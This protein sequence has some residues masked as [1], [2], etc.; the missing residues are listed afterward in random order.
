MFTHRIISSNYQQSEIFGFD[1][2]ERKRIISPSTSYYI[3]NILSDN[4][5]RVSAFGYSNNLG[6]KEKQVAVKTGTTQNIK[7]NWAIG[8][9]NNFMVLTWIGNNDGTQ[10][11]NIASGYSSASKLWRDS[12]DYIIK[13]RYVPEKLSMPDNMQ[14]VLVCPYTN[15]LAC[16]GC[17]NIKR[18]YVKGTEPKRRCNLEEVEKAMESVKEKEKTT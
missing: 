11:K 8:Y 4:N 1:N 17:A 15:T 13:T 10:M 14:E 6:I 2:C 3:S 16:D 12:F 18:I 5:A 7:D 9:T